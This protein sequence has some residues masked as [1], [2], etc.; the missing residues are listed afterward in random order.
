MKNRSTNRL[1]CENV[2]LTLEVSVGL[3]HIIVALAYDENDVLHEINF[4]GGWKIGQGIGLLLH[5]LGI[6]LSRA[7]QGRNPDV[8]TA[9][10]NK[11]PTL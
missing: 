7:I 4:V 6:K 1:N 3:H 2:D 11:S 5:D 10:D 8:F 9:A